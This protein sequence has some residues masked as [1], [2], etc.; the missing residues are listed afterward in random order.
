MCSLYQSG[1]DENTGTE[2]YINCKGTSLRLTDSDTG[3]DQYEIE[4]YYYVAHSGTTYVAV[5]LLF[6]FPT[7]V[8]LTNIK[9]HYYTDHVQGLPALKFYSVPDNFNV[10]AAPTSS[11]SYVAVSAIPPNEDS[12][13]RKYVNVNCNFH[14]KRVL[15]R[16]L[17]NIA[18][19]V[20]KVQFSTCNRKFK[21]K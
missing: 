5:Q 4:D 2:M 12:V 3:L 16:F 8:S 10:W 14:T 20:S 9:L 15:L 1:L 11:H 17:N 19:A 21:K 7:T 18:F 13:G 6:I